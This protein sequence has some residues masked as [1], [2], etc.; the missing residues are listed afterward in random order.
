MTTPGHVG[1][2]Y[3]AQNGVY[4][5]RSTPRTLHLL[6][7]GSTFSARAAQKIRRGERGW[8]YAVEQLVSAGAPVPT[9]E[10]GSW[11]KT[12]IAALA[13]VRHPGNHRY[14]WA[15][16]RSEGRSLAARNTPYPRALK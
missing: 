11:L 14:A 16:G 13:R 4:L 2:I 6:P 1:Q 7:D 9:G 15:F 8:R 10:L 5:G 12:A 3:Q